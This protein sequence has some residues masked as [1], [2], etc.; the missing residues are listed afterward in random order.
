MST[1]ILDNNLL[2]G[3][4]LLQKKSLQDIAK[5]L[6]DAAENGATAFPHIPYYMFIGYDNF[7][8]EDLRNSLRWSWEN[9]T[10]DT[11]VPAYFLNQ[12]FVDGGYKAMDF[13]S[14]SIRTVLDL[15]GGIRP[16]FYNN[17]QGLWFD[18]SDFDRYM[19]SKGPELVSNAGGPFVTLDGW[20]PNAGNAT[21]TLD[22]GYIVVTNA[23]ASS[24][25]C[26]YVAFPT[27]KDKTYQVLVDQLA[28]S[29]S[30][31]SRIGTSIGGFEIGNTQAGDGLKE[32]SFKGTGGTVYLSLVVNS[33]TTGQTARFR[34]ASVREL[35]ALDTATMFQ[36]A[37]GTTPVTA[38][39]QPVGLIL[40]RSKGLVRGVELFAD[41]TAILAGE[42]S[43]VSSGVYRIY[44]SSGAYSGV[45]T[46]AGSAV[47]G[48]YYEVTFNVDSITT[49]G[50][51]ITADGFDVTPAFTTT[52]PKRFVGKAT[53]ASGDVGIKR[54]N[55]V[56]V[57]YQ[58][59][60]LSIRELPGN[61]AS[62]STA[63]S[64]PVL[65][66]DVNDKYYL[67]FDGVDD[68]LQTGSI[69]FTGTDKMTVVAGVYKASDAAVG[70][71][72]ELSADRSAN[73]GAFDIRAPDN[74]PTLLSTF[75]KGV[76][77]TA[78][79]QQATTT[80][81]QYAAPLTAVV[82]AA[83]DIAGDRS[84]L[85]ISGVL[86]GTATG[87][88][89]TGSF[90]NYPLYIGRRGGSTLPFNGRIH[91]LIVRGAK[92]EEDKVKVLE[93]T[94]ANKTGVTLNG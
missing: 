5:F 14:K 69:D 44:S 81:S 38:L 71:L 88:K 35:T 4:S 8:A 85:R 28:G 76:A 39:E 6:K 94:V 7:E 68:W 15:S 40:D 19:A 31:I 36:D 90:G 58:I 12:G 53:A 2:F 49:A 67:A 86:A 93:K 9:Q 54:F 20:T 11:P 43:R 61:H 26:V 82:T 73:S 51:G 64:R 80:A 10:K 34:S 25:A 24:R 87:D 57:D 75:A 29:T 3:L 70:A 13:L 32:Y 77:T 27:V 92:T 42:A 79:N 66:Q 83:H 1:F 62:Q 41:P 47:A 22:G 84:E 48:R 65:R 30:A 63:A 60:G 23:N 72:I 18:P 78:S 52:G 74:S 37:A 89:G 56:T 33:A 50:G 91:Q 46:A 21:A 16:M 17:E 55:T 45:K 59:S